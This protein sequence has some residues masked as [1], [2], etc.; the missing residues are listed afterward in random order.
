M[1]SLVDALCSFFTPDGRYIGLLDPNTSL[2]YHSTPECLSLYSPKM[3]STVLKKWRNDSSLSGAGQ[4]DLLAFEKDID[5]SKMRQ[6]CF[7]TPR[8]SEAQV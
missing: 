6:K 5:N 1:M 3:S 4:G 2:K 7:T 8:I